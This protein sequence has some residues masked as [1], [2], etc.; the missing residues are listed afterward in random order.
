[1]SKKTNFHQYLA[2]IT[3]TLMT[4]SS[5]LDL[6]CNELENKI[7]LEL[8]KL[9]KNCEK[10]E[11]CIR[12]DLD[13]SCFVCANKEANTSSLISLQEKYCRNCK[14]KIP[15]PECNPVICKC[16]DG[17]CEEIEYFPGEVIVGF[18]ADISCT[19]EEA[20]ALIAKY[21][22]KVKEVI[23]DDP[24]I[25]AV[26]VGVPVGKE[27]EF[28]ANITK[29]KIVEYAELNVKIELLHED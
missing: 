9:S 24:I 26:L 3:I 12:L 17:S 4:L 15:L 6:G 1:M 23:S 8:E 18:I 28:V 22:G 14:Y 5:C 25:N 16:I 20:K 13:C 27:E 19:S 2:I 29:H 10:D 21:G 11:D 7:S